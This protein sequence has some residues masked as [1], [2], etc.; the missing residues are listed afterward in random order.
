MVTGRATR[1]PWRFTLRTMVIAIAILA[2]VFAYMWVLV[3]YWR[4]RERVNVVIEK[5]LLHPDPARGFLSDY[6]YEYS[7]GLT[8]LDERDLRREPGYV[9]AKLLDAA[10]QQPTADHRQVALTGL[11]DYV[12]YEAR[13]PAAAK[14]V[15]DRLVTRVLRNDWPPDDVAST[16]MVLDR[17]VP[18]V[19]L[20]DSQRA[21]ILAKGRELSQRSDARSRL[22]WWVYL[23]GDIGGQEEIEFLLEMEDSFGP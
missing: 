22:P 9:V 5:K 15:V 4:W 1:V 12:L 21:D 2:L 17:L 23:I 7:Y 16:L 8:S 6:R 11:Q 19:G 13:S 14:E 10:R 3:P 20:E 18:L